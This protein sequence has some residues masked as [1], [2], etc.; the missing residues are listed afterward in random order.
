MSRLGALLPQI[1]TAVPGP[2]SKAL[3][4]RL[5]SVESRNVTYLSPRF[6][7]FWQE[8]AGANVRD[9][10]GNVYLDFTGAFGVSLA[11]HAHPA[12]TARIRRQADTLIHGM[13]DV[14]PGALKVD[15]LERLASLSPWADARGVLASTGSEA[16]EIALKTAE[17]ATGRSGILSFQGAYHG[18]TL[19]SL[20]ATDRPAFKEPF[21]QRV[22]DGV[23]FAP[24]PAG[25]GVAD[26]LGVVEEA[27]SEGAPAGHP[28]GAVIVEPIQGR[29]GV[30]IPAEGFLAGLVELARRAGAVV[31]FD[32]IFTGFGRAGSMFAFEHEGVAPDLLCVGKALGGGLP[33]S[34]CL[35]PQKIM[36]AWP[37]SA[38]EAL[39]TST[40]L[41]HPLSCAAALAFLDVLDDENLVER[42]GALGDEIAGRL[43]RQL[44]GVV[45][46]SEVRARGLF[47]GIE[48]ALP[49]GQPLEGGGAAVAAAALAGGLLTLPAGEAGQ[50]VELAPP[51]T[52]TSEQVEA[53]VGVLVA[54]IRS[55]LDAALVA[56]A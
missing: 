10:D 23:A 38:G 46:V 31:I 20:A 56:P 5:R 50:V 39:H 8:A 34:A 26:A 43:R 35:G 44:K 41:G 49:G 48:L 2:R 16:V 13:G 25:S 40:F 3:A 22:F 36:S 9:V 6:P 30:R 18:L 28:I 37:E 7:V 29:A 47:I 4:E 52:M 55:V 1:A 15:L 19:G 17:L 54:A 42:A 45:G 32:E 12:I 14:H 21:R 27:L 33:L 24:F 51:A 53:G 11:G